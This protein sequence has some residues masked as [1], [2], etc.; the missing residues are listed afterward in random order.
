[1]PASAV[2][3]IN[4]S[5]IQITSLEACYLNK[6]MYRSFSWTLIQ[7]LI[8]EVSVTAPSKFINSSQLET[9]KMIRKFINLTI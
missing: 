5:Y 6:L 9:S 8:K 3:I 2:L 1:M 4:F 7:K